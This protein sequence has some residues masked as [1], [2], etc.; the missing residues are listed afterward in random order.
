[1]PYAPIEPLGED[2][3]PQDARLQDYPVEGSE[4]RAEAAVAL[5]LAGATYP[6]IAKHAGYTDAFHARQAVERVLAA[7]VGQD[8]R[9]QLRAVEGKRIERLL[10]ST[11]KKATDSG[12]P[13]H[14]SYVRASL[15][16]IDRH[17]R[18]FGLDAP[19]QMVVYSPAQGEIEA[20]V[21]G[22]AR[23]VVSEL[24]QEADIVGEVVYEPEPTAA[25]DLERDE[26]GF[27][28]LEEED[29]G[30]RQAAG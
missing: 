29:G 30:E 7:S 23:T 26:D 22:M 13:E 5:R 4:Q 17:V 6:E 15:A 8:S 28:Y 1:M 16:L 25:D 21:A 19:Q 2:E 9:D 27:A 20:W 12:D 3:D 10:R 18:L 24:P 11:W 14:L